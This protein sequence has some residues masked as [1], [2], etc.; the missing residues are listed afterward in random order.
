[1]MDENLL[2]TE[3]PFTNGVQLRESGSEDREDELEDDGTTSS[4]WI[5]W[6]AQRGRRTAYPD[7][8]ADEAGYDERAENTCKYVASG[9]SEIEDVVGGETPLESVVTTV[10]RLVVDVKIVEEAKEIVRGM[11]VK[12]VKAEVGKS[13]VKGKELVADP[14]ASVAEFD[15]EPRRSPDSEATLKMDERDSRLTEETL[16]S[17]K[18]RGRA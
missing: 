6:H 16:S 10:A 5:L 18:W 14:S 2:W 13:A 1:M 17:D 4:V 9:L 15:S 12:V 3:K 8:Q 11:V 7:Q